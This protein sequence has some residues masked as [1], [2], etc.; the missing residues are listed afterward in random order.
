MI[1]NTDYDHMD[2]MI[3]QSN[4][5]TTNINDWI[6]FQNQF[7]MKAIEALKEYVKTTVQQL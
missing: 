5:Y 3:N 7:M 2:N 1:P 4:E 6:N